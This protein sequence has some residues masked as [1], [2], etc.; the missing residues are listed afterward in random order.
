VITPRAPGGPR[1]P[2]R[3]IETPYQ[4]GLEKWKARIPGL[5]PTKALQAQL[6]LPKAARPRKEPVLRQGIDW[7]KSVLAGLPRRHNGMG[8]FRPRCH[9]KDRHAD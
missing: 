1:P 9:Q 5:D 6:N 4:D 8:A 7:V 3:V 2:A